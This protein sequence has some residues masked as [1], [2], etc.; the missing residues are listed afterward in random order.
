MKKFTLIELLVVIAIIAIL[1]SMLLPAL[2]KARAAAQSAKCKSNLKQLGLAHAMYSGDSNEYC[3]IAY[4]TGLANDKGAWFYLLKDLGYAEAENLY[5]CPAASFAAYNFD[6]MSYGHNSKT[7][8][9]LP[10]AIGEW[11]GRNQIQT[12]D[13]GRSVFLIDACGPTDASGFY[14]VRPLAYYPGNANP[15]GYNTSLR[16]S[17]QANGVSLDGHVEAYRDA[18]VASYVMWSPVWNFADKAF[19]RY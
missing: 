6:G 5:K 4:D 3:L 15:G 13:N 17:A 12:L 2:S 16:H 18:D 11:P 8:G 7:F 10:N 14:M 19:D 1:A 9:W